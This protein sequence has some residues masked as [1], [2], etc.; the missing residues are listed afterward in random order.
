[1]NATMVASGTKAVP[2][3][4]S[5]IQDIPLTMTLTRGKDQF[6]SYSRATTPLL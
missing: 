6:D 5:S 4:V 3:V 2:A 1:M